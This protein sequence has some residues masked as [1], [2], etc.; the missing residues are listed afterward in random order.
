[1]TIATSVTTSLKSL[2]E[3]LLHFRDYAQTMGNISKAFSLAT[4]EKEA[5]KDV[6]QKNL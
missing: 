4:T 3:H 1:M 2:K 5:I 6:L